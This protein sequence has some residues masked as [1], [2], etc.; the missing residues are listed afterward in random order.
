MRRTKSIR[1]RCLASE[2]LESRS[3]MAGDL[4]HNFMMPHDVNDDGRVSPADALT[5]INKLRDRS[6][7]VNS[8]DGR[9]KP[10]V[11]DDSRVTP[12]DALQ[13]ITAIRQPSSATGQSVEYWLQGSAGARASVELE[14]EGS[15]TELSIKLIS[16]EANHAYA[17]TLNDIAL[18]EL[19]TDSKGRGR[20]IL[21]NGDDNRK[22]LP[23]PS[24]LFVLSPEMEVTIG[25]IINGTIGKTLAPSNNVEGSSPSTGAGSANPSTPALTPIELTAVFPNVNMKA[26]YEIDERRGSLVRQFEVEIENAN[27]NATYEIRVDGE[28]VA[29]L[30]TDSRGAAKLKLSSSPKDSKETLM[31]SAFPTISEGTTITIASHSTTFRKLAK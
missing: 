14:S 16:A 7:N 19:T 10:D 2:S 24:E 31:N 23:L 6:F 22:H 13:V 12:V 17:V 28:Q 4:V 15:E 20:L 21:S 8:S 9:V 18:G 26:E 5:V 30:V 1:N 11:N 29:I 25:Q 27:R 3:L